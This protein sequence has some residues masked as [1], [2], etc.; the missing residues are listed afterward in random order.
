MRF[1]PDILTSKNQ[2]VKII[3]MYQYNWF[4]Q[5][6]KE[7]IIAKEKKFWR[8]LSQEAY[9][10]TKGKIRIPIS[11]EPFI[12]SKIE[13]ETLKEDLILFI[14]ATRKIASQYFEDKEIQNIVVINKKERKIIEKS[15]NED[16]LGIVRIDLFYDKKPKIVEIN[17]DFPDGFFMHD[18]TS[19]TM[20]SNFHA[21]SLATPNHAELFHKLLVSE[22]IDPKSHIFIGY[23][24]GRSFIDEFMLSKIKLKRLGWKNISVGPFDDLAF[25]NNNFYYKKKRIDVIRRGAELFKLRKIPNLISKLVK[26]Q[27]QSNLR[28]INNFKMRLL[29]HKSLLAAVYDS[30]FHKYLTAKEIKAIKILL[31][32]TIKLNKNV[33]EKV[34]REKDQWVL[35][36]SDLAEG[37]GIAV[38]RSLSK[39]EWKKTLQKSLKKSQYWILQRRISVPEKTFS[40]VDQRTGKIITKTKKYDFDPHIILFKNSNAIGNILVRFSESDIL[41]V[42]KGGGLTYAFVE[43]T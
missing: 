28:V 39:R 40:L 23:D 3:S 22:K 42:L 35:K 26:A 21:K 5:E 25:K 10:V 33:L 19:K 12:I 17:A 1:T 41:N 37:E 4:K 8:I 18:I 32:E 7:K 31:P 20:L 15:K 11:L 6:K 38:G 36:P 24:K 16:F 30:R 14:S 29:G 13:Y 2:N 43:K 9:P 34:I 27:E